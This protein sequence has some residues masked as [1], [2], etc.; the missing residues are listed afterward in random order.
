[1][2]WMSLSYVVRKL[3]KMMFCL[4]GGAKRWDQCMCIV[5][6]IFNQDVQLMPHLYGIQ[7][8]HHGISR[9]IKVVKF[10]KGLIVRS[11]PPTYCTTC[12]ERKSL[13]TSSTYSIEWL[14]NSF[15]SICWQKLFPSLISQSN[16]YFLLVIYNDWCKWFAITRFSPLQPQFHVYGWG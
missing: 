1:M 5:K 12:F 4:R 8:S 11:S 9:S 2:V 7:C 14:W 6:P 10:L 3:P 13:K 16:N 15:C